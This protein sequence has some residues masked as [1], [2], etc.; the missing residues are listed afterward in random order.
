ME[1]KYLA[2]LEAKDEELARFV[3]LKEVVQENASYKSIHTFPIYS[4]T[5][6]PNQ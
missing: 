1:T 6:E 3:R 2:D 5:S 4:R